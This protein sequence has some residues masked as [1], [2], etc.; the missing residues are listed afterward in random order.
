MRVDSLP[1]GRHQKLLG[2]GWVREDGE[3]GG[4]A[5]E[6]NCRMGDGGNLVAVKMTPVC[7]GDKGG[8]GRGTIYLMW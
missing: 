4:A 7:D 6:G 3:E 8:W 2:R 1:P 5:G